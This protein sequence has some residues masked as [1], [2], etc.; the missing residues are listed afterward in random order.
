MESL[1]SSICRTCRHRLLKSSVP[2]PRAFSTTTAQLYIPPE[3]PAYID[4]PRPFQPVQDIKPRAKGILPLPRELFPRRRPDKP[5]KQYLENVTRDPLPQNVVPEDQLTEA[6]RY[7]RRMAE[8]R[9]MHLR[10][11]LTEL[12]ARK[13]EIDTAIAARSA[14]HHA[15]RA[16]LIAQAEREDNRL[17]NVSIPS[18]MQ[19]QPIHVLSPEEELEIYNA[20]VATHQMKLAAKHEYRLDK[21]H[22]LYMNARDFITTKEQLTEAIEKTFTSNKSIW[23][24]EGVPDSIATM[25]QR[26]QDRTAESGRGGLMMPGDVA[27]R[28]F[29]DQQRMKKV[30]EKLSGGKL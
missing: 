11:G 18:S 26:G 9:K 28:S 12:H 8:L 7:K 29:R 22:T 6:G 10:S 25:V 23:D 16:R 30:A 21:L 4:V 15:Q 17:T 19:P 27:E 20:R 2:T 14:A 5:G 24:K 1:P 13:T 3:S